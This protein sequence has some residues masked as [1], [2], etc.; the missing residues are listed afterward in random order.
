MN[1]ERHKEDTLTSTVL[2]EAI[3]N[4]PLSIMLECEAPHS[5]QRSPRPARTLNPSCRS[6]IAHDSKQAGRGHSVL[7]SRDLA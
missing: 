4:M 2:Q 1:E 7:C 6:S 3:L 5:T